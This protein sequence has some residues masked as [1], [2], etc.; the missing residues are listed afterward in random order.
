MSTMLLMA[1][2]Y[3]DNIPVYHQLDQLTSSYSCIGGTQLVSHV[4]ATSGTFGK[5]QVTKIH[6]AS[7]IA[8]EEYVVGG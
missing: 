2:I 6:K 5:S 3:N 8:P 4:D 7:T 1:L